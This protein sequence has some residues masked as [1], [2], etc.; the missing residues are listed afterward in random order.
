[1][2]SRAYE[3]LWKRT[4]G[5]PYTHIMRRHPWYFLVPAIAMMTT[6]AWARRRYKGWVIGLAVAVALFLGFVGGHVFW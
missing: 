3:W 5:E 2:I 4:T 1:M 6:M